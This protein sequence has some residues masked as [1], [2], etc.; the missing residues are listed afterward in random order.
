MTT[1][2]TR[3][4]CPFLL[5]FGALLWLLLGSGWLALVD[6]RSALTSACLVEFRWPAGRIEFTQILC[7]KMHT[8]RFSSYKRYTLREHK[9]TTVK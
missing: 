3:T 5:T 7:I 9:Y 2:R 8:R 4:V 6:R 1:R